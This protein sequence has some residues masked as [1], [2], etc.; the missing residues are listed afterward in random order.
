MKRH[1]LVLLSGIL[2]LCH[3]PAQEITTTTDMEH[4]IFEWTNQE[5]AK[6][7][8]PPLKWSDRLAIAA[9][10]H[11][12]EMARHKDLS[13]QLKDE[14]IF[15]ERL[16]EQGAHFNAAAENVGYGN[17]ADDLQDG[18]MNSP[19]HRANLLNPVY[20]EMGV[21]IVRAGDRLW[22]TEDFTTSVQSMSSGDLE[23]AVE[24]EI[25]RKR[26]AHGMAALKATASSGLRRA[27]CTG[28][29]SADAAMSALPHGNV[30]AYAFNFT[31][32]KPQDLPAN[33]VS[34]V[35][36]LS[37]GSYAIGACALQDPASG[38]TSYRVLMVITR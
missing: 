3:S 1:F 6:V 2:F 37:G 34:R 16:A 25:A 29:N 32:F 10:L 13:H 12:D 23:Q 17:T 30:Q 26:N 7:N 31:T 35:L 24:K 11:S 20:T 27:A 8:A 33:L 15:T 21:G 22:A 38:M 18:W 4:Q 36:D 9:R 28:N 19:P 5:R 14:P